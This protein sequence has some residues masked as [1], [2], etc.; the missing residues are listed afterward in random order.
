MSISA[1]SP[2]V[3]S[4]KNSEDKVEILSPPTLGGH[5]SG[6]DVVQ[7][8]LVSRFEK[9]SLFNL[10]TIHNPITVD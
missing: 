6:E 10:G 8:D 9:A 7:D 4:R 1:S 2:V 5:A 3:S